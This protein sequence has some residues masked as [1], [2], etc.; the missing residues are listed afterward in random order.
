M[1]LCVFIDKWFYRLMNIHFL[2]IQ[3]RDLV[4][5]ALLSPLV[6][7]SRV[8]LYIKKKKS[9]MFLGFYLCLKMQQRKCIFTAE[10]IS[11]CQLLFPRCLIWK[12]ALTSVKFTLLTC[13][14]TASIQQVGPVVFSQL[15]LNVS[16]SAGDGAGGNSD[17]NGKTELNTTPV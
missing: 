17:L 8:V 16:I 2:E 3:L 15:H 5:R 10:N 13:W 14:L 9:F 11:Q 1:D 6:Q 12:K 7:L 4:T